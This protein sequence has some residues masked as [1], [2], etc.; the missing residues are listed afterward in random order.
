MNLINFIVW[1]TTGAII[2]WLARGMV[3]VEHRLEEDT[4]KKPL[5][6]EEKEICIS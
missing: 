5:P 3:K 1:L 4:N 2:G 6:G